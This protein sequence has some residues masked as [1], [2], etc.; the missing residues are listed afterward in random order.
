MFVDCI[1]INMYQKL[2]QNKYVLKIAF[3][4]KRHLNVTIIVNYKDLA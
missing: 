3:V 4:N 2:H 1:K